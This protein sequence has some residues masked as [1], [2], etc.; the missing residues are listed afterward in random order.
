MRP[1]RVVHLVLGLGLAFAASLSAA[2]YTVTTTA[3]TGAGSLRQAVTDANGAAGPHTVAFNITGSGTHTIVLASD[4]PTIVIVEGLTIDGTTQPGYAGT[5]L[6]E[7]ARDGTFA[8][9]CL[10]ASFTPLTILALAINRCGNPL[11]VAGGKLI[12]K[13]SRLGT[14]PSGTVAL[15]NGNGIFVNTGSPNNVIGGPAANDRN[16][17]SNSQATAVS[18]GFNSSGTVQNNYIGVDA[19]G[20]V[21]MPNGNGINCSNSAG[22]IIGG[23]GAGEGNLISGN[24]L[25]AITLQSCNDAVVQGN[26]IGTDVTGTLPLGNKRG[27]EA[28]VVTGL[29][30]GGTGAGEGNVIAAS[31][32]MGVR[33]TA[34]SGVILV[35]GNFIGTDESGT[36]RLGNNIGV[37]SNQSTGVVI[38]AATPGGPGGNVIAYNRVGILNNGATAIRANSIHDHDFLGIDLDQ[39]GVTSNDVGDADQRRTN[40][41]N[42]AS[43][44]PEGAGVRIIGELDS[45]PS[46]TFDLEFF[47]EPHCTRFPQ[48]FLEGGH[49]LG[50]TP[51]TTDGSGHA[52][53]NVLFTPVTVAPDLRVTGTAT[54]A[55]GNTSEFSQR[56]ALSSAPLT[57]NT[58]GSPIQVQG[59]QFDPAATVTV[60]GVPATNVQVSSDTFLMA[61]APALPAGSINNIV[62]TNPSGLSGTLPNGYVSNFADV[63]NVGFRPYIGGLV[64]NGLTVG[65]GGPNY[66]PVAPVTRQQ[67][68]VF[69]LRGKYGLCY[70]PPPCTG[71][72]FTD[73]PC[74]GGSF[75]PWVEALA[76]LEITGGCGGGNYCPTSPVNRQQMAVFLLKAFEGSDYVPPDCANATFTDVP[77]SNPFSPWIYELALRQI[78]GG[79]GGS[80]Y[81]PTDPANR[82]QMAVFLV[83]TFGLPF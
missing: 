46:S 50:T 73:V 31:V 38:G 48:D 10:N 3:D 35:Q 12:L 58:G 59:M 15:P 56:I 2:T 43:A 55:D 60:G 76:A 36:L 13:G 79:C 26:L 69:L 65:C 11:T 82:Q 77:C 21:A 16:I 71:T 27:V 37:D 41:P 8:S 63:D 54:S 62:V 80:N 19:T 22:L 24:S 64:A 51:V 9:M 75:D 32:E 66:C 57:G 28:S 25:N 18:F 81:C 70:N 49:F 67:M 72:V 1:S 61:Q 5:P 52:A 4:L 45:N 83:K 53:F 74:T 17:L 47:E 44:V 29:T 14:D 42:I 30:V 6:I 34:D 40:F 7:I 39:N 20:T 78:T 33:L 23:S 68:A